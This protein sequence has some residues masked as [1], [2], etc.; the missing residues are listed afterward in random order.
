MSDWNDIDD[1]AATESTFDATEPSEDSTVVPTE[2]MS[3]MDDINTEEELEAAIAKLEAEDG[4]GADDDPLKEVVIEAVVAAQEL[5]H[6][7]L[8]DMNVSYIESTLQRY[9]DDVAPSKPLS[10][11]TGIQ[12]QRRLEQLFDYIFRLPVEG[13]VEGLEI[14]KGFI[15]RHREGVFSFNHAFRFV[16]GVKGDQ[17]A[18]VDFITLF[19]IVSSGS[20][21][22]PAQLD[23]RNMV[24]VAPVAKRDALIEYFTRV[25]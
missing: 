15:N 21:A 2:E 14:V 8:T 17:R 20:K 12:S 23:I 11:A 16:H 19:H 7:H 3:D 6:Q 5:V 18:H 22:R 25:A 1:T 24:R 13:M 4:S 10:D 9:V